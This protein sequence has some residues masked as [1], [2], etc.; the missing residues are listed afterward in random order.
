M[1]QL[2]WGEAADAA[3]SDGDR[4]IDAVPNLEEFPARKVRSLESRLFCERLRRV[5][6]ARSER[7]R[8]AESNSELCYL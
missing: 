7:N 1:P 8:A 3:A 2:L 5:L 6:T 4:S